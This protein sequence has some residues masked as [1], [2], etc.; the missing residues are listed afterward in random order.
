MVDAHLPG[1]SYLLRPGVHRL[2]SVQP[3]DGDSFTGEIGARMSGAFRLDG[4]QRQGG[5]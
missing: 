4:F 1:T 5:Y 2:Q 3:K